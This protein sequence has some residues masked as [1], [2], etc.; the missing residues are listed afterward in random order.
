MKAFPKSLTTERPPCWQ[1]QQICVLPVTQQPGDI[2]A[3][4]DGGVDGETK[5]RPLFGDGRSA[6]TREPAVLS[7]LYRFHVNIFLV[8]WSM[9][10]CIFIVLIC[11]Y[12]SAVTFFVYAV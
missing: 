11:Q 7:G 12:F 3:V 4:V 6:P 1:G 5:Q 9:R 2:W 10:F 8:L